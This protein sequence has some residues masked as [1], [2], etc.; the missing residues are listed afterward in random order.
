M[1]RC[2]K[3]Q[4]LISGVGQ[5]MMVGTFGPITWG[6]AVGL[7]AHC[8]VNTVQRYLWLYERGTVPRSRQQWRTVCDQVHGNMKKQTKANNSAIRAQRCTKRT[9][10]RSPI[11]YEHVDTGYDNN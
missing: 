10:T 3:A 4:E 8:A 6:A 5:A 7:M 1:R 2:L 11:H 9:L